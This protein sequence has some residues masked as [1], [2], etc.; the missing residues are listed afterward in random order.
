MIQELNQDVINVGSK[1]IKIGD[2]IRAQSLKD[3]DLSGYCYEVNIKMHNSRD[4]LQ[5]LDYC[6][7]AETID[8]GRNSEEKSYLVS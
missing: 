4:D 8:F 2:S 6:D 5:S 7:C 3:L 1:L